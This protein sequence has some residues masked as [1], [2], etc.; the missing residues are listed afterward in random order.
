MIERVKASFSITKKNNLSNPFVEDNR[1]GAPRLE[2]REKDVEKLA[3]RSVIC[4]IKIG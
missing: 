2:K 3:K 1:S 4:Y